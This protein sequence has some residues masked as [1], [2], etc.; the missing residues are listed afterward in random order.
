VNCRLLWGRVTKVGE[1]A[2]EAIA[3]LVGATGHNPG[4]GRSATM[5]DVEHELLDVAM[6]ALCA[7]A[8]LHR[9]DARQPD[10]VSLLAT[11]AVLDPPAVRGAPRRRVA[12][13]PGAPAETAR[14]ASDC[15]SNSPAAVSW[16]T[17]KTPWGLAEELAS[18]PG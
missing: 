18:H 5:G 8:H 10:V 16:T 13:A 2:G 1:E 11:R 12:L 7:I 15:P 6:T 4:K 9:A 14:P 3:A 17:Q